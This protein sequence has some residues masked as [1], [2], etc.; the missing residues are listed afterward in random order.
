VVHAVVD[1]VLEVG[2]ARD[3]SNPEEAA[4]LVVVC[5]TTDDTLCSDFVG[6]A[7]LKAVPL[8]VVGDSDVG[9]DT[10]I[11]VVV[12]ATWLVAVDMDPVLL[13]DRSVTV[14]SGVVDKPVREDK[15]DSELDI[16]LEPE[17]S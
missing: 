16:S 1:K 5:R 15:V 13:L 10:E 8:V 9:V 2:P 7:E 12:S 11:L 3:V 14:V 6:L 17:L 4:S